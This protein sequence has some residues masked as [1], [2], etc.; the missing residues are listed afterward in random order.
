MP[1]SQSTSNKVLVSNSVSKRNRREREKM[2]VFDKWKFSIK[3]RRERTCTVRTRELPKW[4][5]FVVL[6]EFAVLYLKS[7]FCKYGRKIAWASLNSDEATHLS[8][9]EPLT[10]L[11][12]G[13]LSTCNQATNPPVTRP[14]GH[15]WQGCSPTCWSARNQAAHPPETRLLAVRPLTHLHLGSSS[16]HYWVLVHPWLGHSTGNAHLHPTKNF[17]V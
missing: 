9:I 2:F 11:R 6:A 16:T 5:N 12:S 17:M 3:K 7:R 8:G 15:P 10:H 1:F 14:L 13:T 4:P